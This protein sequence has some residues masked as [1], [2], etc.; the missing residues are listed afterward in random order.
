M[1]NSFTFDPEKDDKI[2]DLDENL[3]DEGVQ[4]NP[5]FHFMNNQM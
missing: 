2:Y 3:L 1:R 5:S 4:I